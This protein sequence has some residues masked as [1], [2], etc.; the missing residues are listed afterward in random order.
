MSGNHGNKTYRFPK[1]ERDST[2]NINNTP[3]D[4]ILNASK[5]EVFEP[6]VNGMLEPPS[7]DLLKPVAKIDEPLIPSV[8][9]CLPRPVGY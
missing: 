8:I 4:K 2:P 5:A 9:E 3:V 1:P 7:K 6:S